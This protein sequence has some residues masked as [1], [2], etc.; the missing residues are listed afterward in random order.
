MKK[1]KK[2]LSSNEYTL[3][4]RSIEF[5]FKST[6]PK[7]WYDNDPIKT[8]YGNALAAY[9]PH[10][11]RFIIHTV[12]LFKPKITDPHLL[13]NVNHLLK[14]EGYHAREHLKYLKKIVYPHFSKLETPRY[15]GIVQIFMFNSK[16]VRLAMTAAGE[17]FTACLSDFFLSS[18]K[19]FEGTDLQLQEFWRWHFIEEIEH[20]A[21]AFDLFQEISGNYFIRIYGFFLAF[22]FYHL[23]LK[24]TYIRLAY[25]DK[26]LGSLKFYVKSFY[27]F[28]IK[29]GFTRKLLIPHLRYLLPRF[30]PNHIKNEHLV[31]LWEKKSKILNKSD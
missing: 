16:R 29:P 14:Q 1:A 23:G 28:W 5:E 7:Y 15:L 13:E 2:H 21:V 4:P 3:K 25:R 20:K 24:H 26:Q 17:Y 10:S 18:P 8:Y 30:H 6:Y 19:L 27:Y 12:K 22:L 31:S 11:E 9:V